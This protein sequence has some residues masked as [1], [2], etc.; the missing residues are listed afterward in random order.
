MPALCGQPSP[1]QP[2]LSSPTGRWAT[3]QSALLHGLFNNVEGREKGDKIR[4]GNDFLALWEPRLWHLPLAK[5]SVCL[6]VSA[7]VCVC[8][9]WSCA[10]LMIPPSGTRSWGTKLS[11]Q[12][13]H[14]CPFKPHW[15]ERREK[16]GKRGETSVKSNSRRAGNNGKRKGQRG[17][18]LGLVW[19][20]T[21]EEAWAIVLF[22]PSAPHA[23]FPCFINY[24]TYLPR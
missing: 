3:S 16:N 21:W 20:V 12:W 8:V 14:M 1:H 24:P 6:W 22:N 13:C 10:R 2:S 23:T 11:C 18:G 19:G 9:W 4:E 7:C 5:L 17:E 15:R